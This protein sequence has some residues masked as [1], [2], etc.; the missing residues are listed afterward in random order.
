[1]KWSKLPVRL[2][3]VPAEVE[4]AL[5]AGE[6]HGDGNGLKPETDALILLLFRSLKIKI[7]YF[8]HYYLFSACILHLIV[9][10]F[11]CY[12]NY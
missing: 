12:L 11:I 4:E 7:I 5:G 6:T 10:S 3:F 8:M 9:Y 1:M 2:G